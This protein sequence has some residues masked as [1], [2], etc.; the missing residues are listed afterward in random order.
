MTGL[1]AKPDVSALTE[2]IKKVDDPNLWRSP[3]EMAAAILAALAD[4]WVLVKVVPA[5]PT[6]VGR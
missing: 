6:V 4:G 3:E 5:R 2:A 1:A